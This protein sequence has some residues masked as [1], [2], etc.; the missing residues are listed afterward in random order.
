MSHVILHQFPHSHFCIRIRWALAMKGIPFETRNYMPSSIDEVEKLSGGWRMVPVLQWENE[1]ITDSPRIARFIE[2]KKDSPPLYPGD[3]TAALC[4]MINGW[5]DTKVMTSAARFLVGDL[6]RFMP[7]DEDRKRYRARFETAH[8]MAPE[9]A[10]AKRAEYAKELESHWS[11][12]EAQ[13]QNQSYLLGEKLSYA[14]LGVA[15]RLR[16]ME[17]VG[18]YAVPGQFHRMREWYRGIRS[19]AD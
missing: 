15:S 5:V 19:I 3:A 9:A 6:L 13:L 2:S 7:K 16:L 14:D 12:I 10:V 11:L 8:G 4:D 1:F 18:G 17:M